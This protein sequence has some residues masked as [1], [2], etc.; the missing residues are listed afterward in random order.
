MAKELEHATALLAHYGEAKASF[1]LAFAHQAAPATDYTPRVF[2][3]ILHYLPHA[4]AA[5]DARAAQG[6]HA[7][8]CQATAAERTQREQ[9][10]T[11]EQQQL[12]QLRAAL[13][14]TELTTLEEASRARLVA[15]GTPEYAL[16]MGVQAA[17]DQVL[18]AQAG[19][20]SF[21]DWRQM[22]EACG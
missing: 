11:W 19:L 22:Q 7:T 10:R 5:Y 1:L 6:T 12:E 8:T 14:P 3:G 13:S 20:P 21:E 9:H 2:G 4:L 17:V 18:A 15:E 16:R